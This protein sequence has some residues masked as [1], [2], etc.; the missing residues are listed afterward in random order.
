M[1][2]LQCTDK[3]KEPVTNTVA[4]QLDKVQVFVN[5]Q[6]QNRTLSV[7]F[8]GEIVHG[9]VDWISKQ[10]DHAQVDYKDFMPFANSEMLMKAL[11]AA[12]YFGQEALALAIAKRIGKAI[13]PLS[14]ED[15]RYVLNIERDISST[16]EKLL[17]KE[18]GDFHF[19]I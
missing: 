19:D 1:C 13:R 5:S 6:A 15:V 2:Y 8:E 14:S 7:P 4:I 18:I 17:E 11:V 16:K 10:I 3:H 12:H 9:I